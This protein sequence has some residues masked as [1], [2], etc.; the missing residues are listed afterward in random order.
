MLINRDFGNGFVY[1][2][3]GQIFQDLRATV[4]GH[5]DLKQFRRVINKFCIG[6]PL[7]EGFITQ[8]VHNESAVGFHPADADFADGTNGFADRAAERTVVGRNFY[9]ETVIIR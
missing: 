2:F 9:E 7:G 8:N 4:A 5:F 3:I 6:F 1:G